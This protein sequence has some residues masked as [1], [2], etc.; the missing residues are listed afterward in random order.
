MGKFSRCGGT[1]LL[2][3]WQSSP[4]AVAMQCQTS[5]N[6]VPPQQEN[7]ATEI[8]SSVEEKTAVCLVCG[9]TL[10]GHQQDAETRQI[11]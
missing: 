3:G 9:T 10:R 2:L 8:F 4:A 7:F 5:S 6:A 1:A 11:K